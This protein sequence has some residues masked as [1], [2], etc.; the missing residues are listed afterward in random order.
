MPGSSAVPLPLSGDLRRT[1]IRATESAIPSLYPQQTTGVSI[2][3]R[4]AHCSTKK[5]TAQMDT[6]S[7][8]RSASGFSVGLSNK[9]GLL[10]AT[11]PGILVDVAR[12]SRCR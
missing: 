3:R 4:G 9:L 12:V 2:R 1:G 6:L 5:G 11:A 7:Q 8:F 10:V